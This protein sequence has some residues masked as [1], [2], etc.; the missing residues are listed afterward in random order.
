MKIT[1]RLL[2]KRLKVE[3]LKEFSPHEWAETCRHTNHS[4]AKYQ[5]EQYPRAYRI[6]RINYRTRAQ[7]HIS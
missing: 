1:S 3:A 7:G 4:V 5:D 2:L 6:F